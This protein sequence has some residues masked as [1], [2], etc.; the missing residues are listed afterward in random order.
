MI[1]PRNA[2]AVYFVLMRDARSTVNSLCMADRLKQL[3]DPHDENSVL[4]RTCAILFV[5]NNLQTQVK[6]PPERLTE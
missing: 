4:S 2:K 5:T 1:E 3:G 6:I